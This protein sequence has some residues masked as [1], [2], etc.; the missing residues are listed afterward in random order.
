MMVWSGAKEIGQL[1]E[2][3]VVIRRIITLHSYTLPCRSLL[4]TS[5]LSE[6]PSIIVRF[7]RETASW[8]IT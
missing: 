7:R 6:M 4:P 8:G 3:L 2:Q 1:T 5:V